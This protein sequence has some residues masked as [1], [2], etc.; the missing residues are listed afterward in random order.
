MWLLVEKLVGL[1]GFV[2]LCIW[3]GFH[4]QWTKEARE[5]SESGNELVIRE[6]ELAKGGT[7]IKGATP[8]SV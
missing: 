2:L 5:Q 4:I 3:N 8:S 1:F 7:V 6:I